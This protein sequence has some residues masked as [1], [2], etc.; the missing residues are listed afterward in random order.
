VSNLFQWVISLLLAFITSS[1]NIDFAE[2]RKPNAQ[3]IVLPLLPN[4]KSV[5][6][7]IRE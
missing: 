1:I 6:I 7:G 3:I 4:K 5:A 2:T